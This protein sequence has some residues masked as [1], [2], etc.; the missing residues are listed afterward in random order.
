MVDASFLT[1]GG[2]V[3]EPQAYQGI[4]IGAHQLVVAAL[5]AYVQGQTDVTTLVQATSGAV[6]AT[7]LDSISTPNGGGLALRGRHAVGGDD[8]AIRP[9]HR[10]PGGERDPGGGQP[11]VVPVAADVTVGL[12]GATV[13]PR[14]LDV[15][16]HAVA[17]LAVSAVAGWPLGSPYSITVSA[18]SPRSSSAAAWPPRRWP[19]RPRPG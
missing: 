18:A 14:V 9:D 15:P 2:A 6:V 7:E 16:A 1:T 12:S 11:R 10:G 4:T 17:T 3:L 19:P 13:T 5:A 8:L